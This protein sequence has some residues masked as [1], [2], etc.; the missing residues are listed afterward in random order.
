MSNLDFIQDVKEFMRIHILKMEEELESA[1]SKKLKGG[2]MKKQK[3]KVGTINYKVALAK[4][5]KDRIEELS[6][7]I[8]LIDATL[9]KNLK[10]KLNEYMENPEDQALL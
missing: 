3:E 10:I 9:M 6:P 7:F 1:K 8:E 5:F 2:T 4:K